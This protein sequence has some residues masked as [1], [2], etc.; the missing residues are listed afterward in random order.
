MTATNLPL[1]TG[2][3]SGTTAYDAAGMENEHSD[4]GGHEVWVGMN[5]QFIPATEGRAR[6]CPE[7]GTRG[8]RKATAPTT[9]HKSAKCYRPLLVKGTSECGNCGQQLY[10]APAHWSS[11]Y[12]HQPVASKATKPV[13]PSI[14]EEDHA[15]TQSAPVAV[16]ATVVIPAPVV[17]PVPA[18]HTIVPVI[19]D[20]FTRQAHCGTCDQSIVRTK[21]TKGTGYRHAK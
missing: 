8:A 10:K 18:K 15:A 2:I 1:F 13:R 16:P 12:T 14:L 21:D 7:C 6:N 5:V 3:H 11:E 19:D 9:T 20:E 4:N 17:L